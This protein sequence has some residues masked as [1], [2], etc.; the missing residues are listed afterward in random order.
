MN[1]L[2]NLSVGV[3]ALV[4]VGIAVA[5]VGFVMASAARVGLLPAALDSL[6]YG[7]AGTFG[8]CA[9]VGAS[10]IV[11][12]A[13]SLVFAGIGLS[14]LMSLGRALEA[15]GSTVRGLTSPQR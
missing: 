11:G 6:Q 5:L 10:V 15:L 1:R 8:E 9:A 3:L 4:A 7:R 2:W 13:L 12:L 14:L